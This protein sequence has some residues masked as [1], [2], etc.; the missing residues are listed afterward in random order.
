MSSKNSFKEMLRKE[1]RK[2]K[3]RSTERRRGI[4][5]PTRRKIRNT[6]IHPNN[7]SLNTALELENG[8]KKLVKQVKSNYTK[9]H[10]RS[11]PIGQ[12]RNRSGTRKA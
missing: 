11:P 7:L 9:K 6:I 2:N 8:V 3:I 4:F 1:E 5:V 10:G 12:S